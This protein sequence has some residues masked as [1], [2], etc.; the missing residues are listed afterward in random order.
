M[1]RIGIDDE[2]TR[3][4]AISRSGIPDARRSAAR[5]NDFR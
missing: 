4:I 5:A 3:A 1:N 2:S